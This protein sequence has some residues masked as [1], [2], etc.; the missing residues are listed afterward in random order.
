MG[1]LGD[2]AWKAIGSMAKTTAKVGLKGTG[3]SV[4]T[5]GGALHAAGTYTVGATEMGF[6]L[7][8]SVFKKSEGSIIDHING[9][10]LIP[11]KLKLP[12]AVAAVGGAMALGIGE[13]VRAGQARPA[14][15]IMNDPTI[16]YADIPGTINRMLSP[17]SQPVD[18]IG[19]DGGL[20]QALS[21]V[22][23]FDVV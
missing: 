4:R 18:H 7:G 1:A 3:Y 15:E 14:E 19:S 21:T 12:V 22:R 23:K 10:Q 6:K 9:G 20:V 2:A 13:G 5:A 8:K 16:E 17:R 11:F